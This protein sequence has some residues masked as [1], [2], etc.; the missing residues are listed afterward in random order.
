MKFSQLKA[1]LNT[2]QFK[3]AY[4]VSGGDAFLL[5][6]AARLFERLIAQNPEFNISVF[7]EN[8]SAQEIV[9]ACYALPLCS[10]LRLVLCYDFKGEADPII[11]YLANPSPDCVLVFIAAKLS[12]SFT[13][14]AALLEVVDCARLDEEHIVKW[15]RAKLAETNASIEDSA[16]RLLLDYT[17]RVMTRL[18]SETEKLGAYKPNGQITHQDVAA[19]VTPDEAYKIFELSEAAAQKNPSA[20]ASVLKSLLQSGTPCTVLLGMLYAH[21]R[22]LLYCAVNPHDTSLARKLGVKDYAITKAAQQA[23]SFGAARLKK[24]CDTFH[25]TDFAIKSGEI[26][27]R[28]ALETFI[29][30]ILS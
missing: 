29:L 6:S 1:H 11:R 18:A 22:R 21:F 30:K 27:D 23:K 15:V 17:N 3:P 28:A 12:D 9:E 26:G 19:L 5:H 24:I 25:Q 16:L 20:A 8:A 4:L 7:S 13:K 14:L 10:P 2:Q